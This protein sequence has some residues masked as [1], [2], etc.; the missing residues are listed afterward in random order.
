M[1]SIAS[2]DWTGK[3]ISAQAYF[4]AGIGASGG[5]LYVKVG[6]GPTYNAGPYVNAPVGAGWVAMTFNLSGVTGIADVREIGVDFY[7][8]STEADGTFTLCLDAVNIL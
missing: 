8:P 1:K 4:P 5:K 7:S 2:L 6:A 3:V